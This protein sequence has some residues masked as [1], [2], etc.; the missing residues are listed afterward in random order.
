[1]QDN[2]PIH[3]ARSVQA[4]F[5]KHGIWVLAD[6]PPY[7]PDLNPI[8]NLWYCLKNYVLDEHPYLLDLPKGTEAT[9][10]AFEAAIKKEWLRIKVETLDKLINS[11]PRRIKAI[12]KAKGWHTRY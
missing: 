12:I 8:E 9:R 10:I 5:E 4:W 1:M 11:M 7:S 2:A 6:W 3:T